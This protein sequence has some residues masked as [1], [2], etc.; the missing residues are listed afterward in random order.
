[1][2][3]MSS[4]DS[5]ESEALRVQLTQ[6][7]RDKMV[8]L[9]QLAMVRVTV[10]FS[11]LQDLPTMEL[12][13]QQTLDRRTTRLNK[14][15]ERV[16][17]V[18]DALHTEQHFLQQS[19]QQLLEIKR[20]TTKMKRVLQ[21]EKDEASDL[22]RS[23]D[24]HKKEKER[25]QS[26]RD[27][28]IERLKDL[29]VEVGKL[30]VKAH[31]MEVAGE[32]ENCRR[33]VD[34]LEV[35]LKDLIETRDSLDTE[36][37]TIQEYIRLKSFELKKAK[38][39]LDEIKGS[40]DGVE[41]KRDEQLKTAE[42][43][44]KELYDGQEEIRTLKKK[45]R[46]IKN[47][48][49]SIVD[50]IAEE[51]KGLEVTKQHEELTADDTL[52]LQVTVRKVVEEN[53]NAKRRLLELQ[54]ELKRCLDKQAHLKQALTKAKTELEDSQRLLQ[55]CKDHQRESKE[56]IKSIKCKML[57]EFSESR[58]TLREL[59][60]ERSRF[61]KEISKARAGK[62]VNPEYRVKEICDT[63]IGGLTRVAPEKDLSPI[64]NHIQKEFAEYLKKHSIS[65]EA[66]QPGKSNEEGDAKIKEM[67][68]KNSDLEIEVAELQKKN[69][70]LREL[71]EKEQSMLEIESDFV[72]LSDDLHTE[73]H[74]LKPEEAEAQ[75]RHSSNASLNELF[76][77][78]MRGEKNPYPNMH[79]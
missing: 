22:R 24:V 38:N 37:C 70:E 1:M 32:V 30:E 7:Q 79:K 62:G 8:L 17:R 74:P 60:E 43:L 11:C 21:H 75:S 61:N 6:V 4:E 64:V 3:E 44:K 39:Q 5:A 2:S 69:Q 67:I 20:E 26:R 10:C 58:K 66:G 63:L 28:E 35:E 77:S 54:L 68:R 36:V 34:E 71:K 19:E 33:N 25:F 52:R 53:A 12:N 51:R 27:K 55:F 59:Q 15:R 72:N 14:L 42:S 18:S 45:L 49:S 73:E 57:S 31:E 50:A 13:L 46:E 48:K 47:E 65:E 41:Q 23:L 78:A 29:K 9:D 56:T 16:V 76:Q 40:E